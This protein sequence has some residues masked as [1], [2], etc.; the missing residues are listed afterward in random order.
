MSVAIITHADCLLHGAGIEHPE[1]AQRVSAIQ[2]ALVENQLA[3]VLSYYEAPLVEREF[4]NV[5]H[6]KDYVDMVYS[7]TPAIDEVW[8][9]PD[10][11]MTA[12]SL[13]AA[14]RAAGANTLAIDLLMQQKAKR[15]FSAV[16]PPG[17]HAEHNR[18]MGFCLFN[19][20]AVA[21]A[22]AML[23]Y[24]VKRI[25]IIDFDVH[26]GN[27]TENIFQNEPNVL[28]FS[29]FQHPF[30][31]YSKV[32]TQSKHIFKIPLKAGTKGSE[33]RKLFTAN[34]VPAIKNFEPQLI[35]VSAGFDAH[36]EDDLAGLCLI[37]ADYAWLTTEIKSLADQFC[38]GKVAFTLEGGYNLSALARSVCAVIKELIA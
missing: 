11:F 30:Y 5:V 20:V 9:D 33:Y 6:A 18:A 32:D 28:F 17:H 24:N 8:L 4:L 35:L 34:C 23:K 38:N 22:Y 37:D 13:T 26:H 14:L 36:V 25:A 12:G 31:P 21:A 19:N 29:L 15:V 1:R 2:D 10:T 7:I 3:S 16:R 27:G